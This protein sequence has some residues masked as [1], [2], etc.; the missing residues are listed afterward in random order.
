MSGRGKLATPKNDH[1]V[2]E[3]IE[4][5]ARYHISAVRRKKSGEITQVKH[6][7]YGWMPVGEFYVLDE[8]H[9]MLPLIQQVVRGGYEL[10]SWVM[11]QVIPT[12]ILG[13]DAGIP[14][15][16]LLMGASAVFLVYDYAVGN[17]LGM[18]LDVIWPFLPF[19]VIWMA[20]RL[21]SSFVATGKEIASVFPGNPLVDAFVSLIGGGGP[22]LA[23]AE[24]LGVA[25]IIQ[26]ILSG[27]AK[28]PISV[29]LPFQQRGKYAP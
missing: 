6:I 26:D 1:T 10:N 14:M 23:Y 5:L 8:F 15:S 11:G 18:L 25:D 19:G 21:V 3:G 16:V 28:P 29:P 7:A 2:F 20:Y 9:R 13:F 27:K 12:G 22:L 4:G 17:Q 24:G